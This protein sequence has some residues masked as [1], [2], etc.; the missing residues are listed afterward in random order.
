[1]FFVLR[2]Y[3]KATDVA[4][5]EGCDNLCRKQILCAIVTP[6]FGEHKMCVQ[7]QSSIDGIIL[8]ASIFD[9][10]GDSPL[11]AIGTRSSTDSPIQRVLS[12]G[13]SLLR[14]LGR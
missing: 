7:L 8:P 12:F 4:L 14:A 9:I 5:A 10:G 2:L 3:H 13:R 1:M 11:R 6:H